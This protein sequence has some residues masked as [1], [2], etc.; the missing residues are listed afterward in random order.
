MTQLSPRA[1]L[2]NAFLTSDFC[3]VLLTSY[4]LLLARASCVLLP[5]ACFLL[6]TL[7]R[8]IQR[9][10]TLALGAWGFGCVRR[11]VVIGMRRKKAQNA[12]QG[13]WPQAKTP[14]YAMRPTPALPVPSLPCCPAPCTLAAPLARPSP[15]V[16][17]L[18]SLPP[19]TLVIPQKRGHGAVLCHC[20][21]VPLC[22]FALL[23]FCQ[24]RGSGA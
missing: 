3:F 23:P 16:L 4:L 9:K 20:A 7:T 24:P 17:A 14:R 6:L 12:R 18:L 5:A 22:H 15:L 10:W 2:T 19:W 1:G 13:K 8:C 11:R 21:I